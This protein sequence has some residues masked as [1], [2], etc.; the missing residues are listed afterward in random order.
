MDASILPAGTNIDQYVIGGVLGRGGFGITYLVRDHLLE[1]DFALKEFFPEDLVRREGTSVRFSARPNSE[2]DYRWGLRK[3]YDE[4]RLLAQF[5]HPNIVS[6]RRVFEANDSAYM[7]LDFINGNT[8]EKWLEGLD[9]P[10]TQEEL[11]LIV[12]PLLSALELVHENRTWHLDISPE[13]IMIRA[14]DGAPILVDFGASRFEIKQHSQLVS[15]LVFKT[16]YSAPEQYTSNADHYGAWTDIYAFGATLYRAISGSRPLEAT[17]RSLTDQHL[18]AANVAKANYRDNFLRAIDWAMTLR[19]EK[20]PQSITQWRNRLLEEGDAV[21]APSLMRGLPG[22]TT[23]LQG[24]SEEPATPFYRRAASQIAK[25][26]LFA[27]KELAALARRQPVL[28]VLFGGAVFLGAAAATTLFVPSARVPNSEH[29]V[30]LESCT[31]PLDP[32]GAVRACTLLLE[33]DPNNAVALVHRGKM[34]TYISQSERA[35]SDLN[36]AIQLK[37]TLAE[38][39]AARGAWHRWFGQIDEAIKDFNQA[40]RLKGDDGEAILLRGVAHA[41]MG[42]KELALQDYDAAIARIGEALTRNERD[43]HQYRLRGVARTNK[44]E[45]DAALVDFDRALNLTAGDALTFNSRG[46][47]YVQKRELDR[48]IADF[49]QAIRL[50]PRYFAVYNNRGDAYSRKSDHDQAIKDYTEALRLNPSFG[51]AYRNRGNAYLNKRN[52]ERAVADYDQALKGNPWDANALIGRGYARIELKAF[53]DALAD[54]N[55]AVEINPGSSLAHHH[56]GLTYYHKRD[57]DSAIANYSEA[58][59]V[60]PNHSLALSNRGL[61]YA[62]KRDY[63]RAIADYDQVIKLSPGNSFAL[64]N[65]AYAYAEKQDFDRAISDLDK[66]IG[67]DANDAGAL[68]LRGY[69]HLQKRSHDQAIADFDRALQLNPKDA[70]TWSNRG[71]AHE[72][73]GNRDQAIADYRKTLSIDAGY[74]S[75]VNNLK[76]LGVSP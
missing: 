38:A 12:A 40:I 33:R 3:F 1:K 76:R 17:A 69:A 60:T 24:F 58:I 10:P 63:D 7:L 18:S 21:A 39:Y 67:I 56:R 50:S 68:R 53:D 57:Y 9:S 16:G 47:A 26:A 66:A 32:E 19:P 6:V 22:R 51:P 59:R 64:R 25:C 61:A 27:R 65:R 28:S 23:V 5:N 34:L 75:A 41:N 55:R 8:L 43:A 71:L 20:R 70:Q 31:R 73:K 13:N 36:R 29:H 11:D 2:S 30:T 52:Y 14:K 45:I 46:S 74:A 49:D 4:A 54:L 42:H 62:M 35:L 48:A 15:A 37:P 44:Q 72:R